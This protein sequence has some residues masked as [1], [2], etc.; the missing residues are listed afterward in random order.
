MRR[1]HK[2]SPFTNLLAPVNSFPTLKAAMD[3]GADSVYFGVGHLNMRARAAK[4]LQAA[5]IHTLVAQCHARSVQAYLTANTIIY[6][7]DMNAMTCLLETAQQAGIDAIIASDVAVLSVCAEMG[8][9]VHLST[10]ANISNSRAIEFYARF[11]DV[12]VLAREL[13]LD[14]IS[15]IAAHIDRNDIRGPSG[16]RVQLECFIHGALC[17]AVSGQC[18]MSAALSDH[19]ANRGDC[20][21]PCRRSYH[22]VDSVS[23][24]ALEVE[25]H[26]VLSPRDLCTLG[27]L[28]QILSSGVRFLKIEGRGRNVDYV[29]KVTA[30]Y[31]QA[32]DAIEET[33]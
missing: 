14:Q 11:A 26:Y 22:I 24:R 27:I 5:D 20:L 1:A 23:G 33:R 18:Y 32:I 29:Y 3:A 30:A 7:C 8:L 31:R 28:P 10:Q 19:S 25:N 9:P 2:K 16:K 21:Q 13:D 15:G 4:S 17:V 6:D 12:V